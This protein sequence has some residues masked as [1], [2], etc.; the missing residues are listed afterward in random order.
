MST[1][2]HVSTVDYLVE[3]AKDWVAGAFAG[4]QDSD[5]A[6]PPHRF[7]LDGHAVRRRRLS[8][9]S[10]EAANPLGAAGCPP[11]AVTW[12]RAQVVTLLADSAE[13]CIAYEQEIVEIL[14]V[15]DGDIVATAAFVVRIPGFPP[16]LGRWDAP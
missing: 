1:T 8:R 3:V 5:F 7:E 11:E 10:R 16:C 15:E 14:G 6:L 4:A 12:A 13:G 9:H 2:P